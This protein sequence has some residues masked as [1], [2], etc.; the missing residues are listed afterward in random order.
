MRVDSAEQALAAVPDSVE[1]MGDPVWC[2]LPGTKI[3]GLYIAFVRSPDGVV[4][5][6]VE[7]PLAHFTG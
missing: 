5:E 4:F 6:F 7:R 1:V 3:E 2:P